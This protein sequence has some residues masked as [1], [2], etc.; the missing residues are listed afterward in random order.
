M[1]SP[2]LT[3]SPALQ[4]AFSKAERVFPLSIPHVA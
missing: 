1:S 2:Q 3:S 4:L